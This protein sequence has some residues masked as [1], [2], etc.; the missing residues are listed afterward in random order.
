MAAKRIALPHSCNVYTTVS[1]S[2]RR[3]RF[4]VKQLSIWSETTSKRRNW[5][6]YLTRYPAF[7]LLISTLYFFLSSWASGILQILQ[8][9]WFRERAVF[10]PPGPLTAGGSIRNHLLGLRKIKNVIHQPKSVRIGK[11]CALCLVYRLR[12]T[13]SGGIQDLGPGFSHY[14]PP[15][16]W[17]TYIYLW[18]PTQPR[19]LIAVN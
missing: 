9:D 14:G 19:S 16:W 15:V 7:S 8:S 4:V 12:P 13:A 17:I 10:S 3:S 6:K 2:I 11:N 1:L 5:K 18:T